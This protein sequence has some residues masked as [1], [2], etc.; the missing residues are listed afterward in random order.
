MQRPP[1][2]VAQYIYVFRE[3]MEG[4]EA[5]VEEWIIETH[6]EALF[7]IHLTDALYQVNSVNLCLLDSSNFRYVILQLP[8]LLILGNRLLSQTFMLIEAWRHQ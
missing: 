7:S 8:L 4:M 2:M 1:R 5:H 6:P 3:E